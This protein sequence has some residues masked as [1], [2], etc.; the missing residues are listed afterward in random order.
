MLS[1]ICQVAVFYSNI[2]YLLIL[3]SKHIHLFNEHFS[4]TAT[5]VRMVVRVVPYGTSPSVGDNVTISCQITPN[6]Q[7]TDPAWYDPQLQRVPEQV[8]GKL[9]EVICEIKIFQ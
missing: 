5:T 2:K 4:C 7:V 6:S 1:C 9:Y 8:T 3:L